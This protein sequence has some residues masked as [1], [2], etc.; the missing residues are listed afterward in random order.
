MTQ[1]ENETAPAANRQIVPAL[2]GVF[3]LACIVLLT[4]WALAEWALPWPGL[5]IAAALL[6][7]AVLLWALFLSPRPMLRVDR[8]VAGLIEL[9]LIAAT[10]AAML[11]L[12]AHWVIAVAF[13][14]VA[15]VLGYLGTIRH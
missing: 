4:V 1:P 15:A 6:V 8:F 10:V 13:G 5:L 11:G 12:G 14:L 2:R 3:H 9:L 7:A